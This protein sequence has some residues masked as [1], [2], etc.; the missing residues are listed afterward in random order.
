MSGLIYPKVQPVIGGDGQVVYENTTK[1]GFEQRVFIMYHGTDSIE[2]VLGIL[3]I[4][5]KPSGAKKNMLG[6]GVYVSKSREKAERYGRYVFKLLVY[7]G[8]VKIIDIQHHPDQKTWQVNFGSAWVPPNNHMVKSGL[9]V[10]SLTKK[11]DAHM[12]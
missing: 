4:G 2:A 10:R 7:V 3:K 1:S 6:Q 12:S 9:E 8:R 11:K 5:F